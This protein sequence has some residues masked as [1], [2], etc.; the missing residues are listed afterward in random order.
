MKN[1]LI[2]CLSLM[3]L[4]MLV[5]CKKQD[6][7]DD[8]YRNGWAE[9][10]SVSDRTFFP[11]NLTTWI[12][13]DSISGERDTVSLLGIMI[14]TTAVYYA[15]RPGILH[16]T[17]VQ[18]NITFHSSHQN[19]NFVYYS[20]LRDPFTSDFYVIN[21]GG[22]TGISIFTKV[23]LSRKLKHQTPFGESGV[24]EIYDVLE[25]KGINYQNV[26]QIEQRGESS[27]DF[28]HINYYFTPNVGLIK[29]I[30]QTTNQVWEL[31]QCF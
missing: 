18:K 24:V 9:L 25:V 10:D 23:P 12:Y 7:R 20:I 16:Y 28:N 29:S 1:I 31:V 3:L 5:S 21:K 17:R 15:E 22:V 11:P 6:I 8:L 19:K 13:E 14:D 27:M 2:V 26:A 4:A 30:N